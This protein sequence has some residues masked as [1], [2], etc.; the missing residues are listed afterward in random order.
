VLVASPIQFAYFY[1]DYVGHYKLR[2]AFYYDPVAFQDVAGHLIESPDTPAFYF[3]NDV[4]DASVKWRFYA[5]GDGRA[6]LLARTKYI[7]VG[8]WPDA[9]AGSRL[10]TYDDSARLAELAAA[11]WTVERVITDVDHRRAAVILRKSG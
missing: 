10:V 7:D 6:D 11:G 9:P 1:Y 2:S 5:T 4:D 3:T 8:D